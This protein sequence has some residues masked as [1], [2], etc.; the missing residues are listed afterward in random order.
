M[1]G[2][3]LQG[4]LEV[5]MPSTKAIE[6]LVFLPFWAI[7]LE[8]V[9]KSHVSESHNVEKCITELEKRDNEVG[10]MCWIL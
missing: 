8:V 6:T 3:C 2:K 10:T 7:L 5:Q 1:R 4:Q 9:K